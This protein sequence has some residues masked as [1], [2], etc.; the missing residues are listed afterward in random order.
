MDLDSSL[1]T[2]NEK[3]KVMLTE[4]YVLSRNK[5]KQVKQPGMN[6]ST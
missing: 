1:A 2:D 6:K 3:E 5:N 4:Q